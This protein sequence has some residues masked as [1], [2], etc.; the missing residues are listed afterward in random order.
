M[1]DVFA[2]HHVMSHLRERPG[3][4]LGRKSISNF[5]YLILGYEVA[6]GEARKIGESEIPSPFQPELTLFME[7]LS[8]KYRIL[9][10]LEWCGMLLLLHD[11]DEETAF[12]EFWKEWDEFCLLDET[13]IKND[14]LDE[15]GYIIHH[16]DKLWDDFRERHYSDNPDETEEIWQNKLDEKLETYLKHNR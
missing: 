2:E 1:R 12:E 5:R 10:S 8:W 6:Y 14:F 9:F 16:P 13:E 7:W 15:R 3:M 4:Y 11:C